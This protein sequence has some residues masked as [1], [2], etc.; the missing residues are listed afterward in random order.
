[1]FEQKLK[2][3]MEQIGATL[4]NKSA[5]NSLPGNTFYLE[6][7][8]DESGEEAKQ[9]REQQPKNTGDKPLDDGFCAK[10]ANDVLFGST[11]GAKNADFF[12]ALQNG[13]VGDDTNHD[14][15]NNER[16][17]HKGDEDI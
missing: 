16:D 12:G 2:S 4:S 14:G 15:A 17:G 3:I 5:D 10:N 9:F 7:G 8:D 11:N 6:N 13:D 1:M